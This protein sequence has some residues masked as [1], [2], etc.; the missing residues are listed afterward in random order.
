MEELESFFGEVIQMAK[1]ERTSRKVGSITFEN[2]A[3]KRSSKAS[4][5]QAV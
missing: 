3:Y 4:K 2:S 5:S 1:N